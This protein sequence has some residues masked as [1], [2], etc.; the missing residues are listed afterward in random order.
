[1]V[2]A[3]FI[4]IFTGNN[5]QILK[6]ILQKL[7][8]EN[9]KIVSLCE[10]AQMH[11][12]PEKIINHVTKKFKQYPIEERKQHFVLIE[13]YPGGNM[14]ISG[15]VFFGPVKGVNLRIITLEKFLS[16]KIRNILEFY[17]EM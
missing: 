13:A 1:M 17:E 12:S 14:A 6:K 16:E 15:N 2:T 7:G 8:T 11:P 4:V 10:A 3:N 9:E 5:Q